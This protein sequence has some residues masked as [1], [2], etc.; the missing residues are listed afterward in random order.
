MPASKL[1]AEIARILQDEGYIAG[2]KL[3]DEAATQA[4]CR[5][6]IRVLLKYGTGGERVI[7]GI[8]RVSRPGRRVYADATRCRTCSAAWGSIS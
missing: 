3:V 6:A 5:A 7:T 8:E 1:K 2:F 4:A